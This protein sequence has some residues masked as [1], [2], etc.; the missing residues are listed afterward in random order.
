MPLLANVGYADLFCF[1]EGSTLVVS[2]RSDPVGGLVSGK[3][4][5]GVGLMGVAVAVV[6]GEPS[7]CERWEMRERR[8]TD[9]DMSGSLLERSL[10]CVE[11][12]EGG[13]SPFAGDCADDNS[14]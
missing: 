8:D 13:F 1:T 5:V 4:E 11:D 9:E 14:V 7:C 3:A 2:T 12:C 10:L 6:L